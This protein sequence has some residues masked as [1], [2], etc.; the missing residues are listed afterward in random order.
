MP[1]IPSG[2]LSSSN[3][4]D[5]PAKPCSLGLYA[6]T[7]YDKNSVGSIDASQWPTTHHGDTRVPFRG[8]FKLGCCVKMM[9]L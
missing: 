6:L 8:G 7:S 5:D 2:A 1:G 3:D 9:N 4:L